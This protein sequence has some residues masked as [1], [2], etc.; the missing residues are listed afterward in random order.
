M[1][2]Q[3]GDVQ[4]F[5]TF[6]HETLGERFDGLLTGLVSIFYATENK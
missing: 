1:T 2:G 3:K 4:E 5:G 6:W